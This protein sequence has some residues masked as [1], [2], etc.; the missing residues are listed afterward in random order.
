[1]KFVCLLATTAAMWGTPLKVGEFRAEVRHT[2]GV[3]NGLP[4]N[5]VRCIAA[6][7]SRVWAGTSQG[8]TV[9][10]AGSWRVVVLYVVRA[11]TQ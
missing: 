7:G 8:M 4:S 5:D 3:G 9:R 2:F 10:E 6:A 11:R 1:M